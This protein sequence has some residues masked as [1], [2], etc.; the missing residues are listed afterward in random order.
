MHAF[1]HPQVVT[2]TGARYVGVDFSRKICGVSV[3][4]SGARAAG[5]LALHLHALH[6]CW[7]KPAAACFV[8]LQLHAIWGS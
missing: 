3:I 6:V 8:P 2:P 7:K 5:S 4:R 1:D